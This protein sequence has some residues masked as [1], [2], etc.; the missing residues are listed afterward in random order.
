MK[1]ANA[2]RKLSVASIGAIVGMAASAIAA[3]AVATAAPVLT[4]MITPG[5]NSSTTSCFSSA[6]ATAYNANFIVSGLPAGTYTYVWTATGALPQPI[7]CSAAI[8]N[9][10][11]DANQADVHEKVTVVAT[12]TATHV[13]YTLQ[14]RISLLAVCGGGT[15]YC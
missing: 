1:I 8:C 11:L 14:N 6:L 15:Y 10:A 13:A 5:G 3:P 9:Q 12:N 4:C 2:L 7:S